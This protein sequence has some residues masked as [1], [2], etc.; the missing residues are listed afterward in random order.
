VAS[1]RQIGIPLTGQATQRSLAF[2]LR[3]RMRSTGPAGAAR[4][5]RTAHVELVLGFAS[6]K[7]FSSGL[8]PASKQSRLDDDAFRLLATLGPLNAPRP[9]RLVGVMN[10]AAQGYW[11][12]LIGPAQ[13]IVFYGLILAAERYYIG[14]LTYLLRPFLGLAFCLP[15]SSV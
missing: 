7:C 6:T 12:L 11:L 14:G 2:P 9:G 15:S 3:I 1:R 10:S 5:D 4:S 8:P 13:F